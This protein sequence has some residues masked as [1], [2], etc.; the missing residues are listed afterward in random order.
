MN[1]NLSK[2][3]RAATVASL[4]SLCLAAP[5]HAADDP[6]TLVNRQLL[7]KVTTVAGK[8]THQIVDPSVTHDKVIPG[9]HIVV[10]LTYHNNLAQPINNFEYVDP[11]PAPLMLDDDS[12]SQFD[13]SVDGGKTFGKIANLVVV[14]AKGNHRA[15]QAAD[16][17]AIKVV[18]AQ[19]APGATGTIQFHA[20]VR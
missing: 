19:I 4:V 11:L 6:L 20:I 9:S 14:D 3:L 18:I 17:N 16:V 7:D 13:V 2:G 5:A 15:A 8:T 10:E 12:A 1:A